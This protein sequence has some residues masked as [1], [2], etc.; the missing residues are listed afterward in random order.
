MHTSKLFFALEKSVTYCTP[1][2]Y[3]LRLDC[4]CF[5]GSGQ[6]CDSFSLVCL[7]APSEGDLGP[8]LS[9]SK[10]LGLPRP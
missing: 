10:G 7:S 2:E 4:L 1:L 9:V 6:I 8:K 5:I 3:A